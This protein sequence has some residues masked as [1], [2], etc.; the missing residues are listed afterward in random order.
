M[1]NENM[2]VL[3]QLAPFPGMKAGDAARLAAKS[4][5]VNFEDPYGVGSLT[6]AV[7]AN[8]K[9]QGIEEVDAAMVKSLAEAALR[10]GGLVT[11][12]TDP[13]Q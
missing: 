1:D 13:G 12:A 2:L 5:G 4:A 9:A 10:G 7:I 3:P 6:E 8:L 11:K